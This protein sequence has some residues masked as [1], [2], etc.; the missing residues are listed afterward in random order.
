MFATTKN[1]RVKLIP[2]FFFHAINYFSSLVCSFPDQSCVKIVYEKL[3]R[4]H[5]R[6]K[7][8]HENINIAL[9]SIQVWDIIPL[10]QRRDD[11]L[12][13]IL[14]AAD[15]ELRA[16]KC[17]DRYMEVDNSKKLIA[18]TMEENYR[19]LF[20]LPTLERKKE[21]GIDRLRNTIIRKFGRHQAK[22]KFERVPS[23]VSFKIFYVHREKKKMAIK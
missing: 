20:D 15:S 5:D 8:S 17:K 4:L 7:K 11:N 16:L 6:I 14:D 19:L 23:L 18:Y 21:F 9:K 10:H 13:S 22:A 1:L 3:S 12:T 2:F